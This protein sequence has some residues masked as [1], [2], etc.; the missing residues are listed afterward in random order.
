M[1]LTP[2]RT[3]VGEGESRE[4]VAQS[5]ISLAIDCAETWEK[6]AVRQPSRRQAGVPSLN[7]HH[8]SP[9]SHSIARAHLGPS[10]HRKDQAARHLEAVDPQTTRVSRACVYKNRVRL[11]RIVFGGVAGDYL[12]LRVPSQVTASAIR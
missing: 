5:P 11:P 7:A 3:R 6:S 9:S 2:Q 4:C 8:H 12:N 1:F 10:S